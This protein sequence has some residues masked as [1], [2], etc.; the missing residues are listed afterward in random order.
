MTRTGLFV[1]CAGR[2]DGGPETYERYLVRGIAELDKQNQ[3]EIFCF[4]KHAVDSFGISQNNIRFHELWPNNRLISLSLS[5]PIAMQKVGLDKYHATFIPSPLTNIPGLFTMH[6]VSPLTHPEFYP[7]RVRQRLLPMIK[8]G[9]NKA[10]SVICISEDCRQTTAEHFNVPLEKMT[11]VHH[12]VNP[13]I[14][15]VPID[16]AQSLVS[17][18][19]G[20]G[21]DYILYL[22]KL[23]ARKNI[24]R[25]LEAFSE[26][27][28]QHKC[29]TKL[30]LAGR[31][32]WDLHGIDA[33]ISRLRLEGHVIE[34]GYVPEEHLSALYSAAKTFV[35]PT[36]WEGFGFPILEAFT[37]G[38]P[39]ITSNLS[40]LPEIAGGAAY[41]VDPLSVSDIAEAMSTVCHDK[42]LREQMIESGVNRAK[43]FTWAKTAERTIGAYQ[44]VG[45]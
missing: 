20:V 32:F 2:K 24:V 23:E 35:F 16:T 34:T 31:R 39:V 38:T 30:V 7:K 17:E 6:D 26:F 13:N 11:V 43:T 29:N 36:L 19:Y 40:C 22:G 15:P 3:Y 41:L 21:H 10:E 8:H 12:G 4:N 27:R 25:I 5:L 42:E 37:C 14:K 33:T 18:H 28:Q 45:V 1:A 9:L 44:K